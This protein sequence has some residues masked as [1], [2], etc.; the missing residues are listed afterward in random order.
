MKSGTVFVTFADHGRCPMLK[1]IY[2]A[3]LGA[4]LPNPN[5]RPEH[6]YNWNLGY[7]QILGTRTVAQIVL[8]RSAFMMRSSR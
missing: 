6:S 2:S 5:L 3:S 4:G 7:K 1:D 8:F